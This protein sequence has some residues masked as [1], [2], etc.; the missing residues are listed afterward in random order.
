M[1]G[2]FI[3][4]Q[5]FSPSNFCDKHAL[6]SIRGAVFRSMEH[7]PLLGR[8]TTECETAKNNGIWYLAFLLPYALEPEYVEVTAPALNYKTSD[9]KTLSMYPAFIPQQSL[10]FLS[11]T[12]ST[13]NLVP[14]SRTL[15]LKLWKQC[16]RTSRFSCTVKQLHFTHIPL[17]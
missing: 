10:R 17:A 8:L 7:L 13:S 12:M 16:C 6:H 5:E 3:L 15:A 1:I 4:V 2:M 14:M 11:G 9:Q